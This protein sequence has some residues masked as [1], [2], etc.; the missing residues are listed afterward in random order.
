MEISNLGEGKV[1]RKLS[2]L[3]PTDG[4]QFG[5]RHGQDKIFKWTDEFLCLATQYTTV[6]PI[7]LQKQLVFLAL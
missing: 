5:S 7:Q 6:L 2:S 1:A 4:K 3:S